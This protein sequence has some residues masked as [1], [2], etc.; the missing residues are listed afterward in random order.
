MV[1]SPLL[2]YAV[3]GMDPKLTTGK[4]AII[5]FDVVDSR[6][7][8]FVIGRTLPKAIWISVPMIMVLYIC[9]NVAFFTVLTKEEMLTADAVAVVRINIRLRH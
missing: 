9:A 2:L 4:Q 1:K 3:L 5:I 7:N 8:I 6:D